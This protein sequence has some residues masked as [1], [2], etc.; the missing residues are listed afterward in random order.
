MLEAK[1]IHKIYFNG[2]KELRVLKD[3]SLTVARGEFLSIVGPSGAGKSTL[4]HILGGL[5]E[6]SQGKVFLDDFCLSSLNDV[7]KDNS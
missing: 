3:V 5:D 1:N 2:A 6:P 7:Q 4:L